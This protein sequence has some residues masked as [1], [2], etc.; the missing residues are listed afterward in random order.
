MLIPVADLSA[1]FGVKANGVLHVGAHDAEEA[2]DYRRHGWGPVIWVEMLP[3]KAAALR[4]TFH[5]DP[6]NLVIEAACWDR[7][8][9]A[10]D[11]FRA[12]NGQSSSLLPPDSHLAAHPGIAF[13]AGG[14]LQTSRLDT[15]LPAS[16]GF[17]FINVDIQGAELRALIGLGD[18][19]DRVTWAYLEV[20]RQELYRGCALL[21][22]IDRFMAARGFV[23]LTLRM[24]A[25][26]WGDALYVNQRRMPR[27]ALLR[28]R[29]KALVPD[30]FYD[31]GAAARRVASRL[32]RLL[33]L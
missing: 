6:D 33:K 30:F 2:E 22:D 16:A 10:A 8:G 17:D 18:F 12:D 25:H 23:R 1:R 14:R 11:L 20:N 21:P 3:D 4:R 5:D 7:D 9:D 15:I 32:T 27:V 28:L 26:G 29:G 13:S 24:T 31:A 19:M